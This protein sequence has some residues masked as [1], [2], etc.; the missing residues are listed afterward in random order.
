MALNTGKKTNWR[1]WDVIIILDIVITRVNALVSDQPEKLIFTNRCGRPIS[2]VKIPGLDASDVDHINIAGVDPS[3]V[4]NIEIP[5]GDVYI[6]EPQVIEIF[7][8]DIPP[9]HPALIEPVA[10]NQVDVAL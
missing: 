7:D 1:S 9:T 5:G 2:D 6:Q 10:V 3:E 8:P 4:E